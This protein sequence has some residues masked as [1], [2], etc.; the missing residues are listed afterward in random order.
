MKVRLTQIDG[1]LPNLALMKLAS[2]HRERGDTVHFTHSATPRFEEKFA[3]EPDY[4]VVYGSAIFSFSRD[5][6]ARFRA[7]FPNAIIGGTWDTT[8]NVTVEDV[9]GEH[10]H[11]D[12]SDYSKF[13]ASIGFTQRGC[14]LKCGFCVVPRKEGKPHSV[15]TIP[16]IWR[17]SPYP[18]HVH[19]LDNDFFGQPRDQWEARLDEIRLGHFKVCLNQGINIRMIDDAAAAGLASIDYRDDS[20]SQKRIYTAWDNVG[21]EGRFFKGMDILEKHGI[22]PTHVLAYMLIGYDKR[23]TW[24]RLLY[25]FERMRKRG[26]KP[27]PMLY[28]PAVNKYKQMQAGDASCNELVRRKMTLGDFQRWAIG[29]YYQVCKFVDYKAKKSHVGDEQL[30]LF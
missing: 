11:Y 8:N 21:D 13:T 1:K 19:L 14:R 3:G 15:S 24:E 12:Y 25:R 4:D 23:E 18:K 6:V 20:F 2:Y 27:Y 30:M 16:Q 7:E 10:Q 22:P 17:G 26:I 29:R 28:D 5:K 9:I